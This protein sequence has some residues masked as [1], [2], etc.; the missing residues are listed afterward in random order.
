MALLVLCPSRGR[1]DAAREV[2]ASFMATRLGSK[3]DLR[4]VVDEDDP[5][6]DQYDRPVL[7]S[8]ALGSMVGALNFAALGN[9]DRYDVLGFIGDDHR[10]R[11]PGW[12]SLIAELMA[13]YGP[14]IAYADDL[15]QR[16]NLPT[17]VFI[18]TEIV[19]ALGYMALP[20]CR[21][22]YV[23]NAWKTLGEKADCLYY[24]PSIIIEHLHPAYGKGE[25]DEGHLRVNSERMYTDDH[26]AYNEWLS[27]GGAARDGAIVRDL[28]RER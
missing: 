3:T 9:L 11:T 12:D 15:A 21:H 19:R 7:R 13:R 4:F 25:W 27:N 20:T 23:D 16:Q 8:P 18:S 14:G 6:F 2:W 10:F 28:V 5:T 26:H 22:L 17:Q 24:M 1:P